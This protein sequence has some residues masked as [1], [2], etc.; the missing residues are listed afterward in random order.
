MGVLSITLLF[1]SFF[2]R[3]K[4][5]QNEIEIVNLSVKIDAQKAAFNDQAEQVENLKNITANIKNELEEKINGLNEKN[6]D[7]EEYRRKQLEKEKREQ[8]EKREI[9]IVPQEYIEEKP[10]NKTI[11]E[12]PV[13]EEAINNDTFFHKI[14]KMLKI[15]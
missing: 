13:L 14:G 4:I 11:D 8:E 7:F 2:L 5:F 15:Y 6:L 3:K 1:V 10:L 12:K 9:K